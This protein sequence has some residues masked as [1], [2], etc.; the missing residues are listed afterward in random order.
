MVKRVPERIES[1]QRFLSDPFLQIPTTNSV[2]VVWF[3]NFKGQHHQLQYGDGLSAD[4]STTKM[5]KMF[6]DAEFLATR[7]GLFD[8]HPK[9]CLSSRSHRNRINCR[10][11][12]ELFSHQHYRCGAASHKCHLYVSAT[13]CE[14]PASENFAYFGSAI[15]NQ[16]ACQLSKSGGNDRP[17]GCRFFLLAIWSISLTGLQNGSIK[18]KTRAAFFSDPAGTLSATQTGLAV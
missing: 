16:L 12:G 6:E 7:T 11:T 9:N 14:K 8:A 2:N 5:S 10:E 1:N 4:A 3:T 18:L 15:Q 17:A 13:A